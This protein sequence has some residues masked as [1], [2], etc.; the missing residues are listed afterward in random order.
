MIIIKPGNTKC[1]KVRFDARQPMPVS[2]IKL[3]AAEMTP[4]STAQCTLQSVAQRNC[5]KDRR[6]GIDLYR[7]WRLINDCS[8]GLCH[9]LTAG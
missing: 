3:S 7:G 4:Q 2:H 6:S 1:P 5:I 8:F 9:L